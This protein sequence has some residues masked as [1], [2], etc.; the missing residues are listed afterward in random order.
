MSTVY[1]NL[2]SGNFL[3]GFD[4]GLITTVNDWSGVASITGYLGDI[5]PTTA[6]TGTNPTT[7]TGPAL[8]AVNV[9]PN[10]TSGNPPGG[11]V[12]EVTIAGDTMVAL[13][14]SG[15]A[16]APSLVVYLNS[17]GRDAVTID[18]D[19]RDIDA[20]DNAAQ[21]IAVQYRTSPTGDWI[22]VPGGYFADVTGTGATQSMQVSLTLPAGASRPADGRGP[23]P[24]HQCRR[25]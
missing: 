24:H 16:D 22:N 11:G 10:T 15:T 21:P 5:F 7:L 4:P 25:Q 3:Q 13:N 8:G 9:T 14:G 18:F 2:G 12:Y 23:H 6:P 19:V 1:F 17:T 20:T